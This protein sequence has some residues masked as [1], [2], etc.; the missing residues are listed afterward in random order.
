M[1]VNSDS[2][3]TEARPGAGAAEP[4]DTMSA[5]R[6]VGRP[7]RLTLDAIVDAA[8]RVGIERLEMST[9]AQQLNTGVATLYGY[10]RGR[11]HLLELVSERMASRAIADNYGG[12]W[13]EVLRGHA[14]LCFAMFN[15]RPEMIGNLI[16]GEKTD[17]EVAYAAN[18]LAMLQ[19]RGLSREQALGIYVETNQAVIGAAVM[20]V[21][22]KILAN[23]GVDEDGNVIPLPPALGDYRP[24]LDRI[25][26]D[27]ES[28]L[29]EA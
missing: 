18:I 13:Q 19:K 20:L 4:C 25:V 29:A 12:T 7:R 16:G 21:R 9:V 26:R 22:R 1:V 23:A 3:Q 5:K 2:V 15:S 17:R 28:M 8:C 24:T 10:V 14:A 11:D 27:C 6:A